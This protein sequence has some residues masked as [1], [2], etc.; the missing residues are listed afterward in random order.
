[1][2]Q[3]WISRSG[4]Q[5]T[6]T[7]GT[8]WKRWLRI[9]AAAALIAAVLYGFWR[10]GWLLPG[11]IRWESCQVQDVSGDYE[12]TLNRRKVDITYKGALVFT[13]PEKVKVQSLLCSD[14]D[15]DG[16]EEFVLLCWKRGRYGEHKPFWVKRDEWQWSQH[17]FVYEGMEGKV[18]PKWMSS[19]IGQDVTKLE[20]ALFHTDRERLLLTDREGKVNAY[21]W[22]GFGFAREERD[23]SFAVF[24][25][26][27]IHEPIYRYGLSQGD[28]SFLFENQMDR[29]KEYDVTV[30]NQETPFVKDPSAYSDYPRFGTPVEV[31]KA[32]KEA[33]FDVV[34]CAT[35]HALD[36]GAEGVNV[37]KT[38]LQEDGITCLGIQKADEKEY[39][40]YEL[41]K[42]KGVCFA[43]FNY[44]YGTNGIR[45]PE[46]APYMVHL[47]SEEDQVRADLEKARREAD[48]V[49]VFVHW[50]TEES[51]GTDAFQEKWAGIF[52]ESGVDVVVGTHPHV[53]QPY[54]LLEKNGHQMLVYYSIGNFI[55]AQPVKSCQKGGMAFFTMSPFKDGYHVTDYGLTPL[56]IT[57][58]KGK[59]YR[60]K[61]SEMPDQAVITVPALPRS[62]SET[63]SREVIRTLPAGLAVK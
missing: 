21:V 42:R 18:R 47:L 14:I 5:A 6:G 53:L 63:H 51:K 19:Y 11:W 22:E 39:R 40:P 3:K 12:L 31:E 25:D 28:F 38:L 1:M 32:I 8:N 7:P 13:T 20:G 48:A 35:N 23:I 61:Y 58:E 30:I 17:I 24:G 50:G 15:G 10:E 16:A 43:L 45:L 59:G 46:D 26:I 2:I 60:T 34:T 9:T 54:E 57:W 62:A 29:L 4:R 33:G 52:L 36:Q 37:T 27:L 44:T 49:I 56:T 41:L 55:S